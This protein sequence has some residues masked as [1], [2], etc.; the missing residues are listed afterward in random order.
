MKKIPW[1]FLGFSIIG[2]IDALYLSIKHFMGASEFCI[3]GNTC[4]KVLVSVYSTISNIPVALLGTIYY[5]IILILIFNYFYSKK[6]K[7][8]VFI[9]Y[10]SCIGFSASAWFVYLQL[11]VIKSIC[12]YCMISAIS[13]T[14]LFI[15]GIY[16]LIKN[17]K[18]N[19]EI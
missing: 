7:D 18:Q 10:I 8:L 15:T 12:S 17:N 13:S 14:I 9:S 6:E 4:D 16:F 19:P 5:F 1:V 3:I 2:F 11:F